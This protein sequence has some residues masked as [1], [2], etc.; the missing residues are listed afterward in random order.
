MNTIFL[1]QIQKNYISFQKKK[2]ISYISDVFFYVNFYSAV[3][4]VR[5]DCV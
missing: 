3:V 5:V 1:L 4:S 2:N